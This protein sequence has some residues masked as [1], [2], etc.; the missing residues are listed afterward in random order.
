MKTAIDGSGRVVIPKALRE[1]VGIQPGTPVEIRVRDGVIELEPVEA[2]VS[3]VWHGN[4]LVAEGKDG[5]PTL[6]A[7]LVAETIARAAH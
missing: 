1:A 2:Q 5:S 3:L 7:D 6:T 4:V